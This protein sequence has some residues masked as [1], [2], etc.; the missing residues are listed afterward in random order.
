MSSSVKTELYENKKYRQ[1]RQV[2]ENYPVEVV[3]LFGS[4]TDPARV[5]AGSDYDFAVLFAPETPE[6]NRNILRGEMMDKLF[7]IF[8]RDNAEVIDLNEVPLALQFEVI[9]ACQV[10]LCENE[11]RR[12]EFEIQVARR[13][14]DQTPFFRRESY[15]SLVEEKSK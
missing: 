3:Y 1:A 10:M 13:Y 8:G 4:R 7:G 11:E 9:Q 12:I 6:A 2:F 14:Q 5:Y 15:R